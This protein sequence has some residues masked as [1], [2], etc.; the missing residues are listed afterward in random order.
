[1]LTTRIIKI[2]MWQ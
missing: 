1:M 2:G